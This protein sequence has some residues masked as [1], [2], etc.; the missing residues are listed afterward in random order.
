VETITMSKTVYLTIDDGPSPDF[1][2]K[3]DFL[4]ARNIPAVWFCR[5]NNLDLRPEMAVEAIRRGHIIANHSYSH[6]HFS[7]ITLEQGFA[8]IRAGDALVDEV[9]QRAGIARRYRFFRF[10]YGDKGDPQFQTYLRRLGYTQP[11]F[12]DITYPRFQP[13]LKD[14]DW[15][16]TYDTHDWCPYHEQPMNGVDTEAKVLARLDENAPDDGRG[17]NDGRSAE[18]LLI[19]D[20][21][22]SAGLFRQIIER[23]LEKG[24]QFASP[25]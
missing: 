17:L 13:L 2:D 11:P 1:L 19:H 25:I 12:P 7:E 16:W 9:Y 10:P 8:E 5:G 14:V 3:L 6:P 15:Y 24:I 4:T 23:L 21:D 18:L 20:F 22:F